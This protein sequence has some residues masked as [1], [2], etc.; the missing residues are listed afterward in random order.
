MD[1]I[2]NQAQLIQRFNDNPQYVHRMN[3]TFFQRNDDEIIHFLK[4]LYLSIQKTM[5]EDAYFTIRV[6]DFEVIEDYETVKIILEKHQAQNIQKSVKLRGNTE[7]RYTHIDLKESD[8][9]LLIVCFYIE[10]YDGFE[11]FESL[12]AVPRVMNN[13]YIVING[14]VRM[15]M[16]QLVDAS[17]YNNQTSNAKNPMVVFK[18]NF[19]PIRV[20]RN[21]YVMHTI[22]EENIEVINF[23]CDVFSKSL[24]ACEY[25]FAKMGL[26][27]GLQFFGLEGLIWIHTT[28]PNDPNKQY[29]IFQPKKGADLYVAVPRSM[30]DCNHV[31][32]S[33]V[34][35]ICLE[36]SRKF[37]TYDEINSVNIWLEALGRHFTL[38]DPRRKATSVLSS[39]EMIYDLMTRE[40][41]RLN[42][43]DMRDSYT[44]LRWIMY[45]YQALILKSNLDVYQKRVRTSE[46]I[47]YLIA[48]KLSKA[49]YALS[50][51][52]ERVNTISIKK[53]ILLPYDYLLGEIGKQSIVVF[54]DTITDCDAFAAIRYSRNGPSAISEGN[55]NAS[56]PMIYRYLHPTS[57]GVLDDCASGNS[58]PG[59]A[60]ILCPLS[61]TYPGGY[62]K[63]DYREPSR[64]REVWLEQME[65]YHLESVKKQAVLFRTKIL[66]DSHIEQLK[67]EDFILTQQDKDRLIATANR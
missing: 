16:Y 35:T 50:D 9:K 22:T 41:T 8:V 39:F 65:R 62:F 4:Q 28:P 25:I 26:I 47:A 21:T 34:Y 20:Y 46:Y 24:P 2:K 33:A 49:V 60:G 12:I 44:I 40:V 6:E 67:I 19:Q 17:T 3:T 45:E 66:E 31:L 55:G 30:F 23:E 36:C 29:Y 61:K 56:M 10:A 64:W 63:P 11:R 51:M 48:S 42:E 53:R 32:Q 1:N 7:N 37:M 54:N 52:G 57:L 13:Q 18:T 5:G 27:M 14:N 58:A 43:D 59:I 15:M 38:T